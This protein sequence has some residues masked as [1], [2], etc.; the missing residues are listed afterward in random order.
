MDVIAHPTNLTREALGCNEDSYKKYKTTYVDFC[1]RSGYNDFSM[2]PEEHH[3]TDYLKIRR[4]E[5]NRRTS[6]W[7]YHS[8]LN[9][10]MRHFWGFRL[11]D[12][13]PR[14]KVLMRS[15][16]QGESV[17]KA[18]VFEEHEL[19]K[20]RLAVWNTGGKNC[21][22]LVRGAVMEVATSGGLRMDEVKK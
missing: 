6:L 18:A 16:C 22:I 11:Q 9:S 19:K 8:H 12:K 2:P 15:F 5:G 21:R 13:Y 7:A 20:F 1:D 3:L 14:I 4:S 17:K 10:V